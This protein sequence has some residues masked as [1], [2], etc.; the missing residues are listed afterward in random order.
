MAP[1]FFVSVGLISSGDAVMIVVIVLGLH[2]IALNVLYPM[3]LGNRLQ[4]NPLAVTM[5][6]LVWGWLWG[7][8]GLLL[9]IPIT[10]A[11]KI[12]FD[13]V[14]SLRPYGAWMGE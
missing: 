1:P 10:A 3:F 8:M 5:A 12:V 11:M 4:L 6:L 14:E 9:A 13:H 7:A 2:L